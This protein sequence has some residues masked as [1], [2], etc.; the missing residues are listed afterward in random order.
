MILDCTIRDGGYYNK[1]DFD[2]DLVNK[3]LKQI[4]E[5]KVECVEI[6]YRSLKNDNYYGPFYYCTEDFLNTLKIPKKLNLAVMINAN[7]IELQ[8]TISRAGFIPQKRNSEYE[9]LPT[10]IDV[11]E[12][13]SASIPM[14][15]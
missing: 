1:W 2:I 15:N 10:I 14:Q 8:K 13:I 5:S 11:E 12:N 3:Y 6:G 7:E 9:F 4:N